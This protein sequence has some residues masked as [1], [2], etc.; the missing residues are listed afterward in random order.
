RV[1]QLLSGQLAVAALNC[2][3]LVFYLILMLQYSILLTS[4]VVAA[5]LLNVL[6]M[7]LI[8][9]QR[10]DQ[11]LRLLQE[12]GKLHGVSSNGLQ[13]IETI[14]SGSSESDFF[15]KWAGYQARLLNSMQ[16]FGLTNQMLSI[17]PTLLTGISTVAV[18]IL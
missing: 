2:V 4:I 18:L 7:R 10:T 15:A 12:Q 13:L 1:A 5:S 11:N 14:K 3:M 8:T 9:R 6:W 16:Q 17:V